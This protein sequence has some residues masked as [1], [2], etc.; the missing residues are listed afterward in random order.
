MLT[1]RKPKKIPQ[2]LEIFILDFRK[3]LHGSRI[4]KGS[5]F[6]SS[7]NNSDFLNI[8]V[9]VFLSVKIHILA[10]LRTIVKFIVN[11]IRHSSYPS[12]YPSID[13]SSSGFRCPQYWNVINFYF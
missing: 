7:E 5:H 13:K 6:I 10:Y 1:N 2:K 4:V 12:L 8:T 9:S 3:V 11:S